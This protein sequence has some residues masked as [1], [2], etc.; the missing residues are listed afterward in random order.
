M[1]TLV[2]PISPLLQNA[3]EKLS[4]ETGDPVSHLVISA[5]SRCFG[6]PH[7]TLFQVSTSGVLVQGV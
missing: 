7:H 6:M 5:L 3:L 1:P 4:L 2:C